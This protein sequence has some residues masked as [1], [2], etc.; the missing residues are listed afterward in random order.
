MKKA[1]ILLFASV[2]S[3]LN[4]Q[5][6]CSS[7]S[8]GGFGHFIHG[9]AFYYPKSLI[10]YLEGP[11]V[12]N[13]S[14]PRR[15]GTI[16]GGEGMAML[17]N[18]LIGGGGFSQASLRH[19]SDSSRIAISLVGGYFKFGYSFCHCNKNLVYA[20]GGIG[21]GALNIHIENF[22]E[23]RAI[24]FNNRE[25][26]AGG[27]KQDYDLTLNYYDL[28]LSFKRVVS[29]KPDQVGG[30]MVGIDFGTYI[31]QSTSEWAADKEGV[32]FGP[33]VPRMNLNPYLRITIGGGGFE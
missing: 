28:G 14:I 30:F 4:A 22:A 23:G 12:L 15:V 13:T 29:E 20:Y 5:Q 7:F 2:V 19:I 8:S 33:P 24:V 27:E 11:T 3:L 32:V 1:L 25:P 21:W 6:S 10:N 16:S 26:L 17:G 31:T 18:F 9:P